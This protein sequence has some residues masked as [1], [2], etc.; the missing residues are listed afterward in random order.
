MPSWLCVKCIFKFI[1]MSVFSVCVVVHYVHALVYVEARKE[2]GFPKTGVI[3]DCK[4]PCRCWELNPDLLEE[5]KVLLAAKPFFSSPMVFE[6]NNIPVWKSITKLNTLFN[7]YVL[8]KVNEKEI[9]TSNN[10]CIKI[11]KDTK[12]QD[13]TFEGLW[14]LSIMYKQML[15]LVSLP[16]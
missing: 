9:C 13:E 12:T 7:W 6:V 14:I 5:Q 10:P 11:I 2:C 1:F 8:I 4:Q 16:S 3:D 15:W